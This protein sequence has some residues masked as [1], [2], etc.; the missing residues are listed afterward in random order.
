MRAHEKRKISRGSLQARVNLTYHE[1]QV[2]RTP[3][4]GKWPG[5]D[6][7]G[8]MIEYSVSDRFRM[9]ARVY[10]LRYRLRVIGRNNI[11]T[12]GEL[13]EAR[14]LLKRVRRMERP[15]LP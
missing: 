5:A 3:P 14:Y 6:S 9:L 12:D 15:R 13:E 1:G 11:M 4:D 8:R 10:W 7:R 2:A